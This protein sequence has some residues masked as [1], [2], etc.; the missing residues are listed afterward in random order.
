MLPNVMTHLARCGRR[1]HAVAA[2]DVVINVVAEAAG[3]LPDEVRVSRSGEIVD[4]VRGY[5]TSAAR[6]RREAIYLLVTAANLSRASVS[7][8]MGI[9][10]RR[11]T[12]TVDAV[13]AARDDDPALDRHLDELEL[14]ILGLTDMEAAA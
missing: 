6:A 5:H 1:S 10:R 9:S 14:T 3:V 2:A 7:R 8:V 11:I 13:I 4:G 12:L